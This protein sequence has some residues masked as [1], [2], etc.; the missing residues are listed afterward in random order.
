MSVYVPHTRYI[1]SEFSCAPI[2]NILAIY[3]PPFFVRPFFEVSMVDFLSALEKSL[4]EFSAI[5]QAAAPD[6]LQRIVFYYTNSH[7]V[8]QPE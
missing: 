7:Y 5:I 1:L 3:V 2:S 8:F 6:L 4:I